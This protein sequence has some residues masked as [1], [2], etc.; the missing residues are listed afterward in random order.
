M[1]TKISVELG[2]MLLLIPYDSNHMQV[3]YWEILYG[4]F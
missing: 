2:F 4:L 1:E 3:S